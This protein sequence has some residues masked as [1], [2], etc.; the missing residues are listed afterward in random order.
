MTYT[1]NEILPKLSREVPLG[2]LGRHS[3]EGEPLFAAYGCVLLE[4]E[5]Y[6]FY[7]HEAVNIVTGDSE[8]ISRSTK[9]L[10]TSG[11]MDML[12]KIRLSP[13]AGSSDLFGVGDGLL[14]VLEVG[15]GDF[16]KDFMLYKLRGSVDVLDEYERSFIEPLLFV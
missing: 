13:V 5:M 16:F 8:V 3:N 1:L 11:V 2:V 14:D 6:G 7:E 4:R 12:E 9:Q 10:T 15:D